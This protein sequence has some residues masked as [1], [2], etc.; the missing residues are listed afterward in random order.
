M[1]KIRPVKNEDCRLLWEWVNEP[2]VRAVAF[3]SEPVPWEEHLEWFRKKRSNPGCSILI[4]TDEKD[5]PVGQVRF[6]MESDKSAE[7]AISIASEQRGYGYGTE[8]IRLACD[9][10]RR[11]KPITEVAAYIKPENAPS[12]RAFQKAG[13]EDR[14]KRVVRGQEAIWMNWGVAP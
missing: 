7:I 6:D 9:Y 2:Q 5:F 3:N 11:Q 4:L 10:F 1:L 13:F 8:A 12:I 14:G